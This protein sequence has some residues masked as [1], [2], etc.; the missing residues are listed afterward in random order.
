MLCENQ[1]TYNYI[2][3]TFIDKYSDYFPIYFDNINTFKETITLIITIWNNNNY[4]ICLVD[5]IKSTLDSFPG[6][7]AQ[8]RLERVHNLYKNDQ[9]WCLSMSIIV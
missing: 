2:T 3:E 7:L 5:K 4:E 9:R 6:V 1:K 8:Y